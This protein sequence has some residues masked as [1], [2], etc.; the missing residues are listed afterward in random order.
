MYAVVRIAVL[1]HVQMLPAR[2][3]GAAEKGSELVLAPT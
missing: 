3:P 2:Y 1:S